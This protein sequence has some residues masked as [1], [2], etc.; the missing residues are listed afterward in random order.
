MYRG[1]KTRTNLERCIMLKDETIDI[2]WFTGLLVITIIILLLLSGC[3]LPEV[4]PLIPTTPKQALIDNVLKTDWIVT[5]SILGMALATVAWMNGSKAAIGIMAG[6]GVALWMQLT[7]VRYAHVLAWIGLVFAVGLALWTVFVKNRA[8][9]DIVAGV[10]K[11][12]LN[13]NMP[14]EQF[15]GEQAEST[16]KIVSKIKGKNNG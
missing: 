10:Q 3:Q 11:Y 2:F 13:V 14:L 9:E 12:K 16:K 4:K 5:A 15:L 6:C 8:L 1:N 7:V